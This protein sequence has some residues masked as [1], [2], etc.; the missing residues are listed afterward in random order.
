RRTIFRDLA[1]LRD[2]GLPLKY[3]SETDRY[4]ASGWLL[5]PTQLTTEESRALSGLALEFG[6]RKKLPF[7]DAAF[8]ASQKIERGLPKSIRREVAR[9]VCFIDV[10]SVELNELDEKVGYFHQLIEATLQKRAMK[11]VYG[12]LT[13]WE[14]IETTLRPYHLLFAKHCWYVLGRS[15]M[16]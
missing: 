10:H 9:I 7:Y 13:E 15:S 12:S 6:Y 8:N 3:D 14:T 5:P 16:H 4:S 2:A 11:L 1:A